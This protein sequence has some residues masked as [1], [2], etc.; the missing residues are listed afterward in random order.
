[1]PAPPPKTAWTSA[2]FPLYAR[3]D[4]LC[5]STFAWGAVDGLSRNEFVLLLLFGAVPPSAENPVC[6]LA[7]SDE[8]A[9]VSIDR[10]V[11][12]AYA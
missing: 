12:Y 11:V 2:H 5:C 8:L 10:S 3:P 4:P 6:L 9:T 7:E 1:M